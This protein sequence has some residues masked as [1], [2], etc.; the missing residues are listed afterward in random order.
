V[1]K[2]VPLALLPL[3]TGTAHAHLVTTGFGPVYDGVS[4]LFLSFDDLLPV[5]AMALLAGLNGRDAGRRTLFVLPLAW[6]LAGVAGQACG[7]ALL[8]AWIT[9]ISILAIGA[10]TAVDRKLGPTVVTGIAAVLGGLHGW[11]NGASLAAAG[12]E[13]SGLLGI[14][15]AVFVLVALLAGGVVSLRPPWT[16]VAIRA[17]GSWIAAIG[18]LYLGWTLR[19]HV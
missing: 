3:W 15:G 19:G 16:R 7:A 13:A 11:L 2:L 14:A 17:A 6:L 12:R 10:L 18:L 1:R 9:S 5:V 4:H 8:P